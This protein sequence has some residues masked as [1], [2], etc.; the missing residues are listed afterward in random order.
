M[1]TIQSYI[2]YLNE[3]WIKRLNRRIQLQ[4]VIILLENSLIPYIDYHQ[5]TK[6]PE[7]NLNARTWKIYAF[8][9]FDM[10]YVRES[11][12]ILLLYT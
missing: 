9:G 7:I 12:E 6:L 4:F 1:M 2:L 10:C 3:K 11:N 8:I 5:R